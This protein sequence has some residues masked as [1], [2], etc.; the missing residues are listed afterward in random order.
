MSRDWT[1][2]L[3][4]IVESSTRVLDYTRGMTLDTFRNNDLVVDAVLRNL[5]VIGEA[6]K[7]LPKEARIAMPDIEW[8]KAAAFRDVIAHHYF[9]LNIGIVW[10]VVE[11]KIPDIAR[12]ANALLKKVKSKNS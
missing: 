2:Y 12:S 9:G 6:A 11:N 3:E 5:E 7:R 1:F 4:D 10:D 8:A